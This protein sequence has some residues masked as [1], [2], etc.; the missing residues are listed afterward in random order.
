MLQAS[1]RHAALLPAPMLATFVAFATLPLWIKGIGLYPYLGVE[2]M[3]W[4]VYAL[5]F[6]LLL[7]YA[8]LPS[9]G[10]GAYFGIGAYAFGLAQLHLGAGLWASLGAAIGAGARGTR[11]REDC[12]ICS[13]IILF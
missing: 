8:G 12:N 2:V 7:G 10:H 5:G 13:R 1:K 9:F 11:L 4:I 6:N 3:I